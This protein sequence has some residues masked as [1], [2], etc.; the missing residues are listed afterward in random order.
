MEKG[1]STDTRLIFSFL[2]KDKKEEIDFFANDASQ[3]EYHQ[4]KSAQEV[5]DL[6][7]EITFNFLLNSKQSEL[8]ILKSYTSYTYKELNAVM[9]NTWNYEENGRLTPEIK[10][11]YLDR[12]ERMTKLIRKF[13]SLEKK[14]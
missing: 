10:Q 12:G 11:D 8:N 6:F 7:G 4:I 5:E 2:G 14:Y 13:P 3:E 1:T 9:R